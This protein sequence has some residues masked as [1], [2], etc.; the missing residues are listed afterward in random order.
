MPANR[1]SGDGPDSNDALED[2]D[3]PDLLPGER[4][5]ALNVLGGE[6]LLA[7]VELLGS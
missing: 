5:D 6:A 3:D 7:L 1:W 2:D 4:S